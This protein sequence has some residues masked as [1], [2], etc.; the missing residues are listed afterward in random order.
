MVRP[1][2]HFYR[3][4]HAT[5]YH[6]NSNDILPKLTSKQFDAVVCDPPY[7]GIV[8]PYGTWTEKEWFK[9]MRI[10]VPECMRVLKPSGSA[11]FVLQPN[12]ETSGRKRTWLWEFMVWIGKEYGI[13]QDVWWW[14]INT[15]PGGGTLLRPSLKACV[16][17]GAC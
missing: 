3:D 5:L 1:L 16:W 4:D 7:P 13:V 15:M 10:L 12:S 6:G 8:R 17:G 2:A 11:V 14:N 9:M